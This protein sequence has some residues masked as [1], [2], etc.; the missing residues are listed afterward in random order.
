MAGSSTTIGEGSN[1]LG[2]IKGMNINS[3]GSDNE[4]AIPYGK[5]VVRKIVVTNASTSLAVSI[6]TVGVYTA[7]AAGGTTVV[8]A[9]TITALSASSKFVDMTIAV[10]ADAV[11]ASLLFV[12]NVLAH[13]VV[14][15]VDVYIFG[16]VLPT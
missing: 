9:A 3:A 14:A 5:Y 12:R 7:A 1:L 8:T 13:G 15:T 16:D 2:Y 6:A 11:T 4:V 10:V